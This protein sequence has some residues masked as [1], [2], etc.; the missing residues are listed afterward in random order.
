MRRFFFFILSAGFALPISGCN[1][2]KNN[3]N[4]AKPIIE[5]LVRATE[6]WNG[7]VYSYPE[8]QAQITLLKITAPVGFRTPVHT[9]PQP[10]VAYVAKGTI[11]CVVT[12]DKTKVF[13]AG[14]SF[15]TTFGDTPHYCE[16]VGNDSAIIFVTY[17]GVEEEPVTIPFDKWYERET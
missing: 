16:S 14:D 5:T 1:F 3:S 10:G 15:A 6:S 8:G 17:A 11:D 4:D 9:H 2:H 12:A 13:S 7:D